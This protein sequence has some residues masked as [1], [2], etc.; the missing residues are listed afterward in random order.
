MIQFRYFILVCL[1]M[2]F[3]IHTNQAQQVVKAKSKTITSSPKAKEVE[4]GPWSIKIGAS[5]SI[6]YLAKNINDHNYGLGYCGGIGYEVNNFLRLSSLYTYYKPSNISPTWQN[7]K[8]NTFEINLEIVAGFPNK[9]T[10]LYPFVGLSYNSLNLHNS[11]LINSTIN[12]KWLGIN[13][14]TG[15]EHNFGIIG[16]YIDYRM[17]VGKEDK[18]YNVMDICYTGGIKIRIPGE[19]NKHTN[20][21]YQN[22]RY[23]N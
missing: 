21:I 5:K 10:L 17:R 13:L 22:P 6:L 16:I 15:L 7:I 14:G 8:A 18:A 2:L 19:K 11:Y 12:N 9:K 4:Y 3:F 23:L 1:G 20:V